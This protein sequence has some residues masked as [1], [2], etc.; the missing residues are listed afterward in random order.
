MILVHN[1]FTPNQNLEPK[2]S[3]PKV[4]GKLENCA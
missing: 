2:E 1:K 4:R 3:I